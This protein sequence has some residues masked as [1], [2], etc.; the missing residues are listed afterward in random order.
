[1]KKKCFGF[2]TDF[3]QCGILGWCMEILFTGLQSLRRRN[4]QLKGTTSLWMF[5]IYGCS[6]LFRPLSLLLKGK[7]VLFRG[8]FYALCIYLVEYLS[9]KIL[10]LRNLCPWNYR[11]SKWNYQ[12]LIRLDYF[13][14]WFFTGLLME[15][16]LRKQDH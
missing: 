16:S 15:K 7:G 6:C 1:M 4:F 13:P 11:A 14:L 10:S 3:L 5:P 8:S 2:F 12:S 9:G